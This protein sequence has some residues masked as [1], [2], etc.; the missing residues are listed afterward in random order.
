MASQFDASAFL[1]ATSE[2]PNVRR[3]P[4][5]I[6]NPEAADGFYRGTI[7]EIKMEMGESPDKKT[8]A[9]RKWLQAIV[10]IEVTLPSAEKARLGWEKDTLILVDRVFIDLT[11]AGTID[12]AVGR[13]RGQRMY[14]EA[15]DMNKPGDSFSWARMQGRPVKVKVGNE[16]YKGEI[17]DYVDGVLKP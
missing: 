1:T 2:T 8:G 9:P 11:E 3:P 16:V 4:L 6:M 12:N 5:S 17:Q 10:P 7:G 15:A 13:N 14:R